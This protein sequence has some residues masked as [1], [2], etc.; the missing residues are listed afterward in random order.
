[1]CIEIWKWF[2]LRIYYGCTPIPRWKEILWIEKFR[3]GRSHTPTDLHNTLYPDARGYLDQQVHPHILRLADRDAMS[4]GRHLLFDS[5]NAL[6]PLW[7]ERIRLRFRVLLYVCQFPLLALSHDRKL[8]TFLS[9]IRRYVSGVND[10]TDL[11]HVFILFD[12]R[13]RIFRW[14]RFSVW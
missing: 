10:P 11:I 7:N 1:M 5:G 13:L 12:Q 6:F 9:D 8:V 3:R 2:E 14:R 4:W